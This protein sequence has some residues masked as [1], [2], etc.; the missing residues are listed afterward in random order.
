MLPQTN[1]ELFI[2]N[3]QFLVYCISL[4]LFIYIDRKIIKR[5]KFAG[6]LS[7]TAGLAIFYS[8]WCFYLISFGIEMFYTELFIPEILQW[9]RFIIFMIS[10]L[11]FIFFTELDKAKHIKNESLKQFHYS[12]TM[13]FII[14]I[15]ILI[16]F[17][18]LNIIG[19]TASM[20]IGVMDIIVAYY[21][22]RI[23]RSLEIARKKKY[24]SKF[25]I[26]MTITGSSNTLITFQAFLG[27]YFTF[28]YCTSILIGIYLMFNAWRNLPLLSDLEWYKKMNRIYVV[29]KKSSI[30][31]YEYSF[32]K[33]DND[34]DADLAGSMFGGITKLLK[35]VLASDQSV[36]TIDHGDRKVYFSH[37]RIVTSIIIV[38]GDSEEFQ[39]RLDIFT[40]AFESEFSLILKEFDGNLNVFRPTIGLIIDSFSRN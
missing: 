19:F 23:Y 20:F 37:G 29:N 4:F 30:L 26:G 17:K 15:S 13:I 34:T 33:I 40:S 28:I 9:I 22:F 35:E 38:E 7:A 18:F 16:P 25:I 6:Y 5:I 31:L 36:S 8:S 32:K 39:K 12:I 24:I 11:I 14:G 1:L 21:Y 3:I 2:Q 27:Y 10:S